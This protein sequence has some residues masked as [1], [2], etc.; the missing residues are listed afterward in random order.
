MLYEVITNL[1]GVL[2]HQGLQ[3]FSI[4]VIVDGGPAR[5]GLVPEARQSFCLSYNFV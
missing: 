4:P 3:P 2:G 1:M 5:A